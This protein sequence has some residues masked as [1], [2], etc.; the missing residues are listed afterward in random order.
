VPIDVRDD[1]PLDSKKF[2]SLLMAFLGWTL[3]I[4]LGMMFQIHYIPLTAMIVTLGF[5]QVSFIF[6][7]AYLDRYIKP[8]QMAA[9][10]LPLDSGSSLAASAAT[11]AT[12]AL[13][14]IVDAWTGTADTSSAETPAILLE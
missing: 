6:G 7:Q 13:H 10:S 2:V 5:V 12:N 4:G 1:R 14:G 11:T 8:L 9:S 3:L